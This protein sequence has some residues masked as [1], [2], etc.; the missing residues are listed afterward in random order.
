MALRRAAHQLHDAQPLVFDD[1]LAVRILGKEH[2]E[3]LRRTPDAERRPFSAALRAFVVARARI[4]ED[5]VAE[6]YRDR[7]VRQY[8]VLGAGLDTFAYRQSFARTLPDL[9]VFEVDHPATQAWKREMLAAAGI[10]VPDSARLVPVDFESGADLAVALADA[11]LDASAGVCTSWLGVVPYLTRD[12]FRTT[13]Q[14][15]RGFG[16][17]SELTFDYSL[18]R[19]ALG[20]V[21]QLMLDSLADRVRRAGEPFQLFMTPVDVG[22]EMARAG[23]EIIE[24]IDNLSLLE[25]FFVGRADGLKPRG[26]AG[27]ICRARRV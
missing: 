6:S 19:E 10:A 18:P 4:A 12:A 21:E 5:A 16:A 27:R 15:L 17:G 14:V 11:G 9:R 8:L 23:F 26:A 1:P 24:N 13:M 25:K 22:A 3:D 20:P 2:A 7:G